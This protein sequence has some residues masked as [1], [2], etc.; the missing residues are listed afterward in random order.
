MQKHELT[1][2][3]RQWLLAEEYQYNHQALEAGLLNE[4]EYVQELLRFCPPAALPLVQLEHRRQRG[5]FV[6]SPMSIETEE[7]VD[8]LPKKRF[9]LTQLRSTQWIVFRSVVD[10]Y[11]RQYRQRARVPSVLITI[12]P[13]TGL[14]CVKDGHHRLT[15]QYELALESET[16]LDHCE[17][18]GAVT[19][20]G[21]RPGSMF[22]QLH[23]MRVENR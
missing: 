12:D 15:A 23:E 21:V 6:D 19:R 8:R 7:N 2:H 13:H 16:S 1:E 17:V 4:W 20:K 22:Y 14:G 9:A 10:H 11:K 3:H 18:V 5:S